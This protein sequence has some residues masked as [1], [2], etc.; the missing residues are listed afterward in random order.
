VLPYVQ[1]H[2]TT[3]L[4]RRAADAIHASRPEG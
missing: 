2:S 1:G 3:E 4:T